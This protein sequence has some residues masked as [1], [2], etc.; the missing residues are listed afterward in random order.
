MGKGFVKVRIEGLSELKAALKQYEAKIAKDIDAT[1]TQA[2]N[3]IAR[4]AKRRCIDRAVASTIT[5]RKIDKQYLIE[6]RG[7][8]SAYIEFGTGNYAKILLGNYPPEWRAMAMEFFING[9]GRLPSS[10]YLY[11]SFQQHA[12]EAVIKIVDKIEGH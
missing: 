9:L 10:P 1:L 4:D 7:D 11:P 6:T 3:N 12:G 5:F 2:G 8:M